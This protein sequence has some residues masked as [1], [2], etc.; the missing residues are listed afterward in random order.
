MINSIFGES[1]SSAWKLTDVKIKSLNEAVSSARYPFLIGLIWSIL[2]I[3]AIYIHDYGYVNELVERYETAYVAA[4]D[5]NK[6]S[7][8]NE[9]IIKR[10]DK[11]LFDEDQ[12][13]QHNNI[14]DADFYTHKTHD[15]YM[16]REYH[17]FC[18]DII[19]KKLTK[20]IQLQIESWNFKLPVI[21][22]PI[23]VF[24]LGVIG[25]IGMLILV[26]WFYFA[27]SRENYAI[28]EFIDLDDHNI[29]DLKKFTIYATDNNLGIIHYLYAFEAVSSRFLFLT[30]GRSLFK[31]FLTSFLIILLMVPS[32]YTF[33][34][35]WRDITQYDLWGE[36]GGRFAFSG[37]STVAICGLV[38]FGCF[39]LQLRTGILLNAW[40]L[41]SKDVWGKIWAE[42]KN[43]DEI[44]PKVAIDRVNQSAVKQSNA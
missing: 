18:K 15:M 44:P 10:Y 37:M 17:K 33:A 23:T 38:L 41:A 19:Y 8:K 24:D 4:L 7:C 6:C 1:K 9:R 34:T 26:I 3:S 29:P 39:R 43:E 25:H 20:L 16:I 36:V 42:H 27:S 31:N 32:L 2:F 12:K 30:P 11:I 5:S 40:N 14:S 13:I 21:G 28:R 22:T 35:D